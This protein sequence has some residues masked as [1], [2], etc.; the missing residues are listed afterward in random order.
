MK[1]IELRIDMSTF[2]MSIVIESYMGYCLSLWSL[3]DSDSI[4]QRDSPRESRL[5]DHRA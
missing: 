3:F 5:Q 2:M 4:M 1:A